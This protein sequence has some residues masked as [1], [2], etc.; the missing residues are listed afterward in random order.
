MEDLNPVRA[1]IVD[2]PARYPWSSHHVYMGAKNEP[3]VTTKF[4]LALFKFLCF[5]PQLIFR[6]LPRY[7]SSFVMK[8]AADTEANGFRKHLDLTTASEST[9]AQAG[10]RGDKAGQ[11]RQTLS[12]AKRLDV[13]VENLIR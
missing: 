9:E 10:A 11:A 3:W 6:P 5:R 12:A 4:A 8:E 7:S 1:G 2:H 13:F